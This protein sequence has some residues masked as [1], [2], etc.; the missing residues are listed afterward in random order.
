MRIEIWHYL[1]VT[2]TFI[3]EGYESNRKLLL[4]DI[5]KPSKCV[6][7]D[8]FWIYIL[9]ASTILQK[10]N[11]LK[12]LF[13]NWLLHF[14]ILS[15]IK[16]TI[17]SATACPKN[18]CNPIFVVPFWWVDFM[19]LPLKLNECTMYYRRYKKLICLSKIAIWYCCY[20]YSINDTCFV[21]CR[22]NNWVFREGLKKERKST[23]HKH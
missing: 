9:M 16:Q 8:M 15:C 21:Y 1:I 23:I 12:P 3:T 18:Y 5:N 7:F 11:W 13:E 6:Q 19:S 17:M 4:F 20:M 22:Q 2:I 14:T 10:K